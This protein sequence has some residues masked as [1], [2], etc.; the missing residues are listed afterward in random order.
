MLYPVSDDGRFLH[1]AVK[2]D[3]TAR[4]EISDERCG[5]HRCPGTDEHNS[6][7]IFRYPEEGTEEIPEEFCGTGSS[8]A[9]NEHTGNF[10][11][12]I[13]TVYASLW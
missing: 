7:R 6:D 10:H 2:H 13:V 5:R 8:H 4:N 11:S 3:R 9:P 1:R 12:S